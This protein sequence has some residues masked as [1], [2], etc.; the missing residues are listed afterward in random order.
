MTYKTITLSLPA[1]E[2]LRAWK[3]PGQSFSDVVMAKLP[4][5]GP[6]TVAEVVSAYRADDRPKPTDDDVAWLDSYDVPEEMDGV[7]GA[8]TK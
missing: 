4:D 8:I 2:R 7:D 5:E 1:Y 6:P 3:R